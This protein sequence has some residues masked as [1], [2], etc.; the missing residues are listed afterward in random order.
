MNSY[1]TMKHLANFKILIYLIFNIYITYIHV[2]FAYIYIV[3]NDH[4]LSATSNDMDHIC[5]QSL[6]YFLYPNSHVLTQSGRAP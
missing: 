5:F 3:C 1:E 4:F 2:A 6:R